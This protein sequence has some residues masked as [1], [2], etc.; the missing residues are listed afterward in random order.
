[1]PTDPSAT[2]ATDVRS[3]GTDVDRDEAL[4]R[5]R[6]AV[7]LATAAGAQHAVAQFGSARSLD[8]QRRCG[9]V[10]SIE[11]SRSASISLQ[12]FV[13]GRYSSHVTSDLRAAPLA[14]FVDDAVALTR[15]LEEDPH[16]KPVPRELWQDRV[17][18]DLDQID[19]VVDAM[20]RDARSAICEAVET[21]ALA[22]AAATSAT[23]YLSDGHVLFARAASDG[24]EGIGEHTSISYG[25][26]VSVKD[27][28]GKRPEAYRFVGAAHR[29]D[30]PEPSAVGAQAL[31]RALLRRGATKAGSARTT[32]VLTPDASGPFVR[33]VLGVL[34]A[35]AVQQQRSWLAESLGQ[36][37]AS[38]R[39]DL[40]DEPHLLRSAASRT[41]DG[42]GLATRRRQLFEA[43]VLR[44]FFVDTY[45]GSKLGWQPTTTGPSNI[46]FAGGAGDLVSL[47]RDAGDGFLVTGWLGG[48]A[49]ATTGDFSFGIVG[50]RIEGGEPTASIAEMNVT[51][52]YRELLDR[53]VAVGADPEPWSTFRSPTLV[54]EGVDFSGV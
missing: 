27:A 33:R 48:N 45:Y 15:L 7:E 16:R 50:Q 25:A 42:E 5:A 47:V 14:S 49:N 6:R 40:W 34:Q 54:F 44:T 51:G 36:Q 19:P 13:D 39:L 31:E 37:V 1:M 20:D 41:F 28:G 38:S 46:V 21:S 32:M 9:R 52:N 4:E 23:A 24:F 30:L 53:L 12:L 29:D 8:M 22:D 2:T 10:E 11:E 18:I 17:D 3:T 26:Q 35:G 43:G